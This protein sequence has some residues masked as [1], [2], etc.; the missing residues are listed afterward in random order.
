MKEAAKKE[1]KVIA[2]SL[3]L[4]LKEGTFRVEGVWGWQF[5]DKNASPIYKNTFW[6]CYADVKS[7]HI[8]SLVE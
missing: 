2:K 6:K 1:M 3:G 4:F 7:G 5:N 8:A